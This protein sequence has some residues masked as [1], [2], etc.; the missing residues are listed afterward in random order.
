MRRK[1]FRPFWSHECLRQGF[2][3]ILHC[4]KMIHR[5]EQQR[6]LLC[7][8]LKRGQVQGI[9]LCNGDGFSRNGI[10]LKEFDIV[11]Q[12]FDRI[13]PI[14]SLCQGVTIPACCCADFQDAHIGPKV[15]FNNFIVE[16]DLSRGFYS[17]NTRNYNTATRTT[18]ICHILY[19]LVYTACKNIHYFLL[20]IIIAN[21]IE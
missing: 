21:L 8:A 13:D 15:G 14:A 20:I 9:A 18:A 10:F 6:N 12:Q 5:A 7:I 4:K 19:R 2:Q 3:L 11:F 1:E 17:E 16:T